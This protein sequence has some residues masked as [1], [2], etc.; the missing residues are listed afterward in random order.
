MWKVIIGTKTKDRVSYCQWM[1]TKCMH[2][3]V[4]ERDI[5]LE[6]KLYTLLIWMIPSVYIYIYSSK[7]C[8]NK[9]SGQPAHAKHTLPLIFLRKTP[10]Y[11]AP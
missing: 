9:G 2:T 3:Q 7:V 8:S 5:D 11:G 6:N 4:T 1:K 10:Y